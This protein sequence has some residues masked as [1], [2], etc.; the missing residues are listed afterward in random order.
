MAVTMRQIETVRKRCVLFG[1]ALFHAC[2]AVVFTSKACVPHQKAT[3]MGTEP[4]FNKS[5]N[6]RGEPR[7]QPR[8]T[9]EN[10]QITARKAPTKSCSTLAGD[11]YKDHHPIRISGT[12][13]SD[14]K[15]GFPGMTCKY[16]AAKR[17]ED[18]RRL[19][20]VDMLVLS[21]SAPLGIRCP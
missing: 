1:F 4:R 3:K 5:K 15:R 13:K 2:E 7:T 8:D 11:K 18:A 14:T 17:L 20:L 6:R 12:G 9:T 10:T 21:S 19:Y 16:L